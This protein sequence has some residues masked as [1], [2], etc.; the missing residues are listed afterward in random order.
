MTKFQKNAVAAIA[1]LA[2]SASMTGVALAQ[3]GR[4]PSAAE[5]EK[6]KQQQKKQP[7]KQPASASGS[8]QQQQALERAGQKTQAKADSKTDLE[9]R[10][11]LQGMMKGVK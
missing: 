3:M 2:L 4:A 8:T 9:K 6:L 5:I 10:K 7:A 11:K 1:F